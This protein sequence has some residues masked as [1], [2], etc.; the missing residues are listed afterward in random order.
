MPTAAKQDIR[1]N[2]KGP[3]FADAMLCRLGLKLPGGADIRHQ[4]YVD[5]NRI[6]PAHIIPELADRLHERQALDIADRSPDLTQDE[7]EILDLILRESLDGIRDM[8]DYLNR[9]AEIVA[10]P[11][12]GDDRRSEEHTSELQSLMRISYAVFC[13]KKKKRTTNMNNKAI[14]DRT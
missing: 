9:R 7:I 2:S 13:L 4:R 8:G 11:F 14:D 6:F 3:Q 12:T 5:E 1:L 10:T